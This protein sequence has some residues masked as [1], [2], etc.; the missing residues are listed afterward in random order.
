M[1]RRLGKSWRRD[2][3]CSFVVISQ[4]PL[5]AGRSMLVA[6]QKDDFAADIDPMATKHG[7]RFGRQGGQRLKNE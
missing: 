2:E 7:T 6:Q 1:E 4:T 3:W 5:S